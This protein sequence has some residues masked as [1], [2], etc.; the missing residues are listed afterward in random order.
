MTATETNT[1]ARATTCNIVYD[2]TADHHICSGACRRGMQACGQGETSSEGS[3]CEAGANKLRFLQ[4][5][6]TASLLEQLYLPA[7]MQ[8]TRG[9]LHADVVPLARFIVKLVGLA[10][11][12]AVGVESALESRPIDQDAA[13]LQ[14]VKN[15]HRAGACL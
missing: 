2:K 7:L 13:F 1:C 3:N 4:L 5:H 10:K 11:C 9:N 12:W 8:Q 6:K 15:F 14:I